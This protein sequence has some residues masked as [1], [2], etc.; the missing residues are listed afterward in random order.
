MR[1]RFRKS[2]RALVLLG[3]SAV[4]PVPTTITATVQSASGSAEATVTQRVA[5]VSIL[6]EVRSVE[7]VS[8]PTNGG[9]PTGGGTWKLPTMEVFAARLSAGANPGYDFDRWV[10]GDVALST[11]SLYDMQLAGE[12]TVVGH[13]SVNQERGRWSPGNCGCHQIMLQYEWVEGRKY[14]YELR[15]GPGGVESEGKWWGLWVTDL[16]TDATSFVGEQRA[17]T[18]INGRPSTLWGP[19][20]SV[21]GEDLYWWRSRNGTEKYVCSDFEASSLAVLD[22]TAGANGDRPVRTWISTNSGNVD[23]AEN[24][25]ETTLCHV[26][27]FQNG[28]DVQHNVGFWPE[29]PDNV[30]VNGSV[31]IR[32]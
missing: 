1:Q 29:P 27:L 26:T 28:N 25:Y 21:F 14:R 5:A 4:A 2:S 22:V 3:A 20:T 18:S 19:H 23:V 17:P 32:R 31:R 11:D 9:I 24:G 10:E 12:H 7:I 8:V 30:L 15:E 13:L 6:P 16:V